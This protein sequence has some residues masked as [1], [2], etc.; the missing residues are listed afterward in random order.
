MVDA[1]PF[2][3]PSVA[4]C[5]ANVR[6]V[7]DL[8]APSAEW[9]RAALV[10]LAV[11]RDDVSGDVRTDAPSI[12]AVRGCCLRGRVARSCVGLLQDGII[13]ELAILLAFA[14]IVGGDVA[15]TDSSGDVEIV[16]GP[17]GGPR[18]GRLEDE[19][20]ESEAGDYAH[21]SKIM[22]ARSQPIRW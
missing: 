13:L 9:S 8:P 11:R 1:A 16:V 19:C 12:G 20:D 5:K 22:Y 10:D 4:P 18:R 3:S 15:I 2:L 21:G 14:L 17:G 7:A 6:F